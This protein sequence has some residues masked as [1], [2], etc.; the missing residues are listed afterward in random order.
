MPVMTADD[1]IAV[2]REGLRSLLR[3]LRTTALLAVLYLVLPFDRLGRLSAVALL[4]GGLVLLMATLALQTRSILRAD[5]PRLRAIEIAATALMLLLVV[6]S[7]SYVSM[8]SQDPA[9]FSEPLDRASA[10]Y[11]CVT[12]LSTVG[13]GDI[14]PR[15]GAARLV[16]SLQ[17][18]LDLV[19]I[20]A[21]ARIIVEAARRGVERKGEPA[22]VETTTSRA[23][24]PGAGEPE[25]AT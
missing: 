13:F 25:V 18:L 12:V 23:A 19:L 14:V 22:A 8:S 2:R 6:F 20:G 7:A 21:V 15:T 9:S 3:V 24:R 16:V 10:L 4:L 5:R 17:M 1:P 11:F